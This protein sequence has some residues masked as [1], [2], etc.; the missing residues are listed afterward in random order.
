[1]MATNRKKRLEEMTG[2]SSV[3]EGLGAEEK[4]WSEGAA[5][6]AGGRGDGRSSRKKKTA[7]QVQTFLLCLV[8]MFVCRNKITF[9][10]ITVTTTDVHLNASVL[11]HFW[12]VTMCT[13]MNLM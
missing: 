1:M 11:D 7:R 6:G 5:E 4:E 10:L 9:D 2:S 13:H 12:I 8:L 3:G